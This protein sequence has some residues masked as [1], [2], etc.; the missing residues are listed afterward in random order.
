MT[1]GAFARTVEAW[2]AIAGEP[3]KAATPP[4]SRADAPSRVRKRL[5]R[6]TGELLG[7]DLADV[8]AGRSRRQADQPRASVQATALQPNSTQPVP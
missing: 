2:A 4:R 7:L 5:R 8:L 1:A 3:A 6:Y